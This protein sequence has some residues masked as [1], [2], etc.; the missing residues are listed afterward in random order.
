M[1]TWVWVVWED[2]L[3]QVWVGVDGG[4]QTHHAAAVDVAGRVLWS[5]PVVNDQQAI[6]E[7]LARVSADDEVLWAVDL[8][9]CETGLLRAMLA[10]AGH[11]TVYVPGRTVKTMAEGFAGEA[12]T[13]ARD[14]VVIANTA[15]MRRDFLPVTPRQS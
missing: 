11:R 5:M 2:D 13:D 10:A 4:R 3:A 7:M 15:R 14:A 8:I 9:G 6:A 12:K 1:V